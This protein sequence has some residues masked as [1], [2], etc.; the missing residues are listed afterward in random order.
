MSTYWIIAF[1]GALLLLIFGVLSFDAWFSSLT[2]ST[3]MNPL[4]ILILFLSM[5]TLS[6]FLD[7]VGFFRFAANYAQSRAK[8][9]QLSLFIALYLVIS[10]LTI[11]TSNDIIILTFTPFI[12]MFAK[13]AKINPIPYLIAEF[14]AANTW[15][16]MLLIGNPTNIY[17]ATTYGISFGDYFKVMFLPTVVTGLVSFTLL[18]LIFLKELQKP[19][20]VHVEHNKINNLPLMIIG[21]L[22]LALCTIFIALSHYIAL[23]M[24]IITLFFVLS[25]LISVGIHCRI[26]HHSL[27]IIHKT[28]VRIPWQL[29]PFVIGM[30]TI[31]IALQDVGFLQRI[32]LLLGEKNIILGYGL[33]SF[34]VSN[35]VNNIPMSIMFSEIVSPLSAINLTKGVYAIIIGSN[36]GAFLSPIGALAGI[37]WMSI[38]KKENVELSF[39]DFIKRN[40]L[41]SFASILVSL[42]VLALVFK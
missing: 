18:L 31:V 7:E 8:N 26:T 4:K 14:V 11:F 29:I 20:D 13:S 22:H 19:L 6:I 30:F 35:L 10:I 34:F 16:M 39:F 28:I 25:L 5:T 36:I 23:D 24:W 12:C 21:L 37:M 9:N 2:A 41:I 32:T 3:S 40:A 38:L 27:S 17:L 33:S 15:S 42:L 1:I